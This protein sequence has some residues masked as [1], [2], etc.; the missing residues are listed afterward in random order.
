MFRR[1]RFLFALVAGG[2]LPLAPAA[3]A[4][5]K[6]EKKTDKPTVAVF[7][8]DGAVTESPRTQDFGLGG[9][10]VVPL[11]ELVERMNKAAADENVKAVVILAEGPTIGVAQARRAGR[12]WP[13]CGPPARRSTLTPTNCIPAILPSWP[14]PAG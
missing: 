14:G 13:R 9:N 1:S 8:L 12:R 6:N 5:D 4:A 3:V 10:Q 7:R 2:L 11:K